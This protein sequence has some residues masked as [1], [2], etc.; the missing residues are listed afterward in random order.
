MS[1][2]IGYYWLRSVFYILIAV[3]AG[4]FFFHIGTNNQAIIARGKCDGLMIC[5]SIGGIPFVIEEL[6]YLGRKD[7][8]GI[9][10]KLCLCSPTSSPHSLSWLAWL[11][12]LEQYYTTWSNFTQDSLITCIFASISYA[13]LLSQKEPL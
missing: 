10:G 2:D 7:L 9:M 11:S 13:A 6:K 4:S 1:R 8:A 12:L 5:L 3:S